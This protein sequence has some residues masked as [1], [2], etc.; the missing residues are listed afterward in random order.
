MIT[1]GI[2]INIIGEMSKLPSD[3]RIVLKESINRTKK[4]N[5]IKVNLAINYVSK[6]EIINASNK[7]KGIKNLKNFEKNL[8]TNNLPD[9]D[10]LIELEVKLDLAILCFGNW[11]MQNFFF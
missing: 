4:N 8:Y 6:K 9:P 7:I 11:L 10:I 2:K 3:L 5:K 1:Q